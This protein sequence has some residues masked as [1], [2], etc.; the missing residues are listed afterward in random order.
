[1]KKQIPLAIAVCLTTVISMN[2]CFANSETNSSFY[3]R[4]SEGW[5]WYEP[6]DKPETLPEEKELQKEI[7]SAKESK[8]SKE[9][10]DSSSKVVIDVKWLRENLPKLR[11][12]AID[13]P[14]YDNVRRYFYAQ[15][16]MM[17]KAS[18]F[19]AVAQKVSKLERPLDETLRRP[20]NQSAL[21]DEKVDAKRN[22]SNLYKQLS[23]KIGYFFFFSSTCVHCAKEAPL[24][25]RLQLD[26]GIDILPISLDGRG[27]PNNE[28]PDYVTDPGQLRQKLHV[29]MTPTIYVV[30]KDGEEFHNIAVGE[31]SPDE[32]MRRTVMLASERGWI[33]DDEYQATREVKELYLDDP[34][35][36]KLTVD[37]N[38]LY[39]DPNYLADK[40]T[41]KFRRELEKTKTTK[42]SQEGPNR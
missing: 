10:A 27:L 32:L 9:K 19:A 25:K 31:T 24:L 37:Q 13:M 42:Q 29:T 26:T 7:E 15:R 8:S 16:I 2:N 1:M 21:Y 12:A 6:V 35:K 28:Y 34:T 23:E 33:T 39:D 36:E 40:L 14:T 4:R 17:D 41:E 20:E 38:K 3:D 11:D 18:K 5:F 30:T 22:R